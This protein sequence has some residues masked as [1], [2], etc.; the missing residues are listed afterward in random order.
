MEHTCIIV[1]SCIIFGVLYSVEVT[2]LLLSAVIIPLDLNP[3]GISE[4]S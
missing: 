2:V 1:N 4:F 3:S